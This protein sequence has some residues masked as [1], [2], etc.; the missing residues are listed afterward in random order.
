MVIACQRP[1]SRCP[2][3]VS[4]V[5]IA[6]QGEAASVGPHFSSPFMVSLCR[7]RVGHIIREQT[8][9]KCA[10]VCGSGYGGGWGGG[11]QHCIPTCG[12]EKELIPL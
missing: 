10:Y 9:V 12:A 4:S 5:L 7:G 1:H 6:S 3:Q 8:G 2:I 11:V